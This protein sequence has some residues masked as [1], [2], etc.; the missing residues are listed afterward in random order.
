M[1]TLLVATQNNGKL[2]ELT[3]LL[4]PINIIGQA[5]LDIPSIEETGLTF[6][7]NALLKARHA[8]KLSGLPALAD[9]SGLV[10][11]A[12]EGAP[13]IHSARYAEN[14]ANDKDNIIKLLNEMQEL[15]DQ[16]REAF[17]YCTLVL[18]HHAN[19]PMPIIASGSV[20]GNILT[21]LQG[22]GGFGYDPVFYLPQLQQTMAELD[23]VKKN[24]ISHRGKALRLLTRELLNESI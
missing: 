22:S 8:S 18:I 19:D 11:P 3:A 1:K 23:A 10:V 15:K 9:D 21:S 14:Q 7:E 16:Q 17:F 5:E 2:K 4:A 12:L 24:R 13:G 20:K 6:V